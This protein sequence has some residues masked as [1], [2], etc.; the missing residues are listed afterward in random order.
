MTKRS[1]KYGLLNNKKLQRSDTPEAAEAVVGVGVKVE[2]SEGVEVEVEDQTIVVK[3]IVVKGIVF[4]ETK[5]EGEDKEIIL[6]IVIKLNVIL[7]NLHLSHVFAI[8][9]SGKV[10]IFVWNLPPAPGKI[11]L[12][13]NLTNETLTSSTTD[14]TTKI[15]MI[16]CTK[17]SCQK[18][19]L[20]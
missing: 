8:G 9:P 7:T 1:A 17:T 4:K 15:F 2:A 14:K 5:V 12:C 6:T 18:Y 19:T 10:L 20:W 13:Q 16:C 3:E 11:F